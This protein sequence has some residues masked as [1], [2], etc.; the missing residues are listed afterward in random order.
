MIEGTDLDGA[1]R[2]LLAPSALP[3]AHSMDTT[4][5]AV[6]DD[7]HVAA[8]DSGERGGV[9]AA[10][11][12]NTADVAELGALRP[13]VIEDEGWSRELYES[14]DPG[15]FSSGFYEFSHE[16]DFRETALLY[17][18]TTRPLIAAHI[19]E[20]PASV[21]AQCLAMPG[22]R[23]EEHPVLQPLDRFAGSTW[24]DAP[25]F[26]L[27]HGDFRRWTED[28]RCEQVLV[29]E[30]GVPFQA[31]EREYCVDAAYELRRCLRAW[32]IGEVVESF[33]SW[34]AT[35]SDVAR[36]VLSDD[37]IATLRHA[38]THT[39][40]RSQLEPTLARIEAAVIARAPT[41]SRPV[42]ISAVSARP[43][44]WRA[45][46]EAL[47]ARGALPLSWLSDERRRYLCDAR[48]WSMLG[49]A[50]DL[51][52]A[53]GV[54]SLMSIPSVMLQAMS[55][56]VPSVLAAE[57]LARE[58]RGGPVVYWRSATREAM[59]FALDRP[60]EHKSDAERAIES[61]GFALDP[62]LRRVAAL[63]LCVDGAV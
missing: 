11:T 8:F 20:L 1:P 54:T 45:T 28:S 37:E 21:Q 22:V 41:C 48:E 50:R 5:F 57:S 31:P 39:R 59:R 44:P 63:L 34:W 7:G 4:W 35:H 46:L 9:P 43:D 24:A 27:E 25:F 36:V 32:T 30:Q 15:P 12:Q 38:L 33:D 47:C 18:R 58:A 53:S 29:S 23:F 10:A 3:A 55:E 49:S 56:D 13:F 19:D 40:A 16:V 61:L 17:V 60:P 51:R 2:T 26:S 62:V 52:D 6:D 14:D 42:W